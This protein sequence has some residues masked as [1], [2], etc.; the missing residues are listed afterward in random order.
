MG[1]MQ[2]GVIAMFD[3][4]G[5]KGIWKRPEVEGDADIVLKKMQALKA[6]TEA[7]FEERF[8]FFKTPN[9]DGLMRLVKDTRVTF[10]SDTIVLAIEPTAEA[11]GEPADLER[12][13]A[14]SLLSVLVPLVGQILRK[15]AT[16]P[17]VLAYRGCVGIGEFAIEDSFILGPAVDDVAASMDA[18]EGA[19]V[20]LHES[21]ARAHRYSNQRIQ[22][23]FEALDEP[24]LSTEE[25]RRL[26]DSHAV[27]GLV[28]YQV[29]MKN[30][31][32]CDTFAIHPFDP[33]GTP[34]DRE[35]VA[36]A[37]LAT[38]GESTAHEAKRRN[39]EAFLRHSMRL[40][41]GARRE[42]DEHQNL[43]TPATDARSGS[44]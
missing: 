16:E 15:A 35:R 39:T 12:L 36:N 33:K 32:P 23:V 26:L 38:F 19:V 2:V 27:D 28:P 1:G 10:I 13:A 11:L 7:L 20:W 43:A 21:A 44:A 29:P 41:D 5:F 31:P 8:A 42:R 24:S 22:E 14:P 6:A 40:I 34:A 9:T 37:L 3:A 25:I 4:L 18:A 30:G 17:P